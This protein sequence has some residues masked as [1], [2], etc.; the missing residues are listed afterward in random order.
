MNST[1]ERELE[2][3]RDECLKDLKIIK[4]SISKNPEE[5]YRKIVT[6]LGGLEESQRGSGTKTAII[7]S[8]LSWLY[9][10]EDPSTAMLTAA[11]LL[12]SDTDTIATM[13][14]AII[15]GI[16]DTPPNGEIQDQQYLEKEALRLF[17]ISCGQI[18]Q[19]FS[20]PDLL[21]WNPPKTQQDSVGTSDGEISVAGLAYAE[22]N[23]EEFFGRGK[24]AALWQWLKL[25]FGQTIF[26]KRRKN[27]PKT[28]KGNLPM[29]P[30]LLKKS[31]K[32]PLGK[33]DRPLQE[34]LFRPSSM[35]AS[36]DPHKQKLLSG[37]IDVLTNEAIQS[38][39]NPEVIGLHLLALSERPDGIE[40]AITY[41]G[42]IAKAKISRR[43]PEKEKKQ[44]KSV[45]KV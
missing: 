24:N 22:K 10:K 32:K 16:V 36:N 3:V 19:S 17:K 28:P 42:I 33:V 29:L 44:I 21:K 9:E 12:H 26:V 43:K 15:G 35:N 14:G 40:K 39:F 27:L 7:A 45:S 8:A 18:T 20:Y 25:D 23:G 37:N 13:A 2:L 11:N 34:D 1:I 31:V 5:S 38:N 4:E 30:L 6:A 41:A